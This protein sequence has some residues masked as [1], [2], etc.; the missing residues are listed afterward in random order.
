MLKHMNCDKIFWA[1]AVTTAC[2]I[3]NRVTTTGLPNNTTPHEIW[4]GKKP[5]IGHLRV[6]GAKCWYMI[7]MENIKELDDRTSEAIMIGYPKNT[8]RYKLWDF[9]T[10]KVVVS[11]HVLFNEEKQSTE[12]CEQDDNCDEEIKHLTPNTKEVDVENVDAFESTNDASELDNVPGISNEHAAENIEPSVDKSIGVR[13]S[14]RIRNAPGPWWAHSAFIATCTEPKAFRQ[15]VTCDDA[16]QRKSAMSA[17]YQILKVVLNQMV[18]ACSDV[19]KIDVS[20]VQ[21]MSQ[22]ADLSNV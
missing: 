2:Y 13:R 12:I 6:F 10:Q 15:A 22:M 5:D 14:G 20:D 21:Q 1:K 4:I 17:E 7:P 16:P 18:L 19:T 3:K 8:N 9:K 11:R